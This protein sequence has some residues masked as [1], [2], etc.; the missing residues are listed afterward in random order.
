MFFKRHITLFVLSLVAT[1]SWL[2][3]A[4]QFYTGG[5]SP[6]TTRWRTLSGKSVSVVAPTYAEDEAR[7]VLFLM[8]SLNHSIGYG[9]GHNGSSVAPLDMPVVLHGASSASNGITIMAPERIEMCTTPA[10]HSYA[11]TWLRQ[12]S[13]HEYR[14]AAQYA[15]LFGGRLP[16]WAYYLLGEQA[17]LATTGV[18]P[19][20]WLEGDAVDAETQASL[21]GRAKQPSYTM[22]YRAIGREVLSH[23]NPDV[24]FSGSYNLYTPSHYEL[25]YQM[26]TTANT[27]AGGY[28]WGEIMD[29]A[30][31]WPI[32]IAP[33]EWAMRR[34]W[35][36]T[37]EQLFRTTFERLNSHWESL[38]ERNDSAQRIA[39]SKPEKSPY[40][41]YRH[42][43]WVDESHIVWVKSSFD[44]PSALVEIDITTGKERTLRHIG[45]L[46]TPPAIV[47]DH[48]YW[49]ELSQLSSFAQDFGSI[50]YRAP[51][52]KPHR[53]ERVLPKST[54]AL[55]PT[56]LNGSLA[57]VR[58]KLEGRYSIV[59]AKGEH[60]LPA[61][62]ECHGM[63]AI[64]DRLF[65][66]TT[67]NGG[68][69]IESLDPATGRRSVVKEASYVTLSDLSA[70]PDG[71]L[72]FGS[73][74]SG[75]NEIHR[76][77]ILTLNE[78]RISTSRYGSF[79]PAANNTTVAMATYDAEG[80]HPATTLLSSEEDYPRVNYS[81][82]PESVVNPE[83][84][85]WEWDVCI[86]S[87]NFEAKELNRSR[88]LFK[89]K[90][91][92]KALGAVGIHSWAPIYYL[93]DQLM[94]GN[95][96]N[97]RFGLTAVSQSL[98]SDAIGSLGLFW[99]PNGRVG[100]NLQLNYI[101]L[102]PKFEL[103]A[104]IDNG[105]A[106]AGGT[107]GLMME[108]GDYY[109]SY[110][111]S[112]SA[113]KPE[114]T[115]YYYSLY[116]RIHLPIVISHS[117]VTTVVTP[118]VELSRSN[119][120]IYNPLS[121]SYVVGRTA[122][123]A[124]IQ[125]NSYTSSAYRN[126][127]PRWGMALVA[128]VGKVFAPIPTTTSYGL[129]GRLYTPAFGANDG[130]TVRASYQGIGGSGPL[131]Y[132]LNFGWLNPRG[133]RTVVYPDDQVGLSLQY[134]TPLCYP[135]VGISGV[136]LL[137]RLRLSLFAE[138]LQGRLWTE[139][140]ERVWRGAKC[141][142]ADLWADTSWLRLPE[143]GD[144][145]I[146]VGAYFDLDEWRKPT[147]TAGLNLNF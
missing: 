53:K 83:V 107:A 42:P 5:A 80:Y 68:M 30:S 135:D 103:N 31:R 47:G 11:T 17:L 117:D 24:W 140:G 15:A 32:T 44:S 50:L 40:T 45:N 131:G 59:S 69:A 76:L 86:D 2:P 7:R 21:F 3:M 128:G 77:N 89:A 55:Y 125:W 46:N 88:Q 91:Y 79:Y 121:E 104:Y 65:L 143:Q 18:M 90:R 26:V 106:A 37:T 43:L 28:A 13:V 36:C 93:P 84:Y 4:A 132:S 137:K 57:Y 58:Y 38:P 73:I 144:L 8:D 61:G 112:E 14:H 92:N 51:L 109:A 67:G 16:R 127:Q 33:F 101:G 113:P 108:D 54:R 35:G 10:T 48:I 129:F 12:L 27:L 23:K 64:G 9:L 142:G 96:S 120:S 98:L 123:A 19:F 115:S 78:E 119:S 97:V 122:A 139:S 41:H 60:T 126:L 52:S 66:L 111:H 114:P 56:N 25:G 29:Y 71:H 85:R 99:L 118:A 34:Q 138:T 110:D 124:T 145:T 130:F 105:P 62:V 1:L 147:F 72:Y 22:H 39:L 20:W 6:A 74:A 116:G 81:R 94:A 82:L 70:S 100:T 134:D 141:V 102:A 75:Y 95:M 146:K 63:A 133:I 136:V 49:C 87:V